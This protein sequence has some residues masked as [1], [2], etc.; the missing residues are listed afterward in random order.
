MPC[1]VLTLVWR[2]AIDS[3]SRSPYL[4]PSL[5]CICGPWCIY[6]VSVVYG[7]YLV[8]SSVRLCALILLDCV[9]AC[10]KEDQSNFAKGRIAS[11]VLP[12]SCSYLL[13]GSS[14]SSLQLRVLAVS[15]TLK[16][17]FPHLAQ[18]VIGRTYVHAKWHLEFIE[19]FK[20]SARM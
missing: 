5:V 10:S 14:S 15:L 16:S 4:V 6:G 3:G 9:P 11:K 13:I 17:P 18:C 20:Q 19:R 12:T 8:H 7:D 2:S 1:V